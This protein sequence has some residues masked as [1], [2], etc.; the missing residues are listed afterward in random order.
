MGAAAPI[1]GQLGMMGQEKTY[2]RMYTYSL[3]EVCQPKSC[4]THACIKPHISGAALGG[5]PCS[6]LEKQAN[7]LVTGG[8]CSKRQPGSCRK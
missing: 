2:A 4:S 5:E 3:A 6:L 1:C 7:H 8:S